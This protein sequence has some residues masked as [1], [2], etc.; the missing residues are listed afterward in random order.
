MACQS[1]VPAP[2]VRTHCKEQH[3]GPKKMS[4]DFLY[5]TG[6]HLNLVLLKAMIWKQET[7]EMLWPVWPTHRW[8]SPLSSNLSGEQQTTY[9]GLR[10]AENIC[11]HQVS[12]YQ[13]SRQYSQVTRDSFVTYFL[14]VYGMKLLSSMQMVK[15]NLIEYNFI[16]GW[17]SCLLHPLHEVRL[18]SKT[19]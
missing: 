13:V 4:S 3:S 19:Y 5:Q 9:S 8:I 2:H 7:E 17:F 6:N 16:A 1:V 15:K 12:R 10:W 18:W 11:S 14:K